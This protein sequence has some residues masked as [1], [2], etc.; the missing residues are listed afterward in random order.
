MVGEDFVHVAIVGDA[1][2]KVELGDT[3][4]LLAFGVFIQFQLHGFLQGISGHHEGAVAL[5]T[6]RHVFQLLT[7]EIEVGVD[8]L[9]VDALHG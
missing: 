9:K 5:V 1:A 6:N 2:V 3:G 8:V 4:K 7:L